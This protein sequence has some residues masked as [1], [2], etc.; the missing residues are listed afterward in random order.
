MAANSSVESCGEWFANK[1]S[2]ASANYGIGSDGRIALYVDESDRA[3]TSGSYD[4]DHQAVTIEVANCSG[5]PEWKVSEV[6]LY[7]LVRLCADICERNGIRKLE[8]TGDSS[9]NL[10]LHKF[11]RPTLCPGPYLESRMP[12]I[13]KQVNERLDSTPFRIKTTVGLIVRLSPDR[14]SQ[15]VAYAKPGVYTITD[16]V[17]AEGEEWGRLKSKAGWVLLN[18]SIVSKI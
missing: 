16:V 4:N 7:S 13:A 8:Y 2:Q 15:S 11:F 17:T 3:W 6:A 10:T 18:S 1:N 14:N 5:G 12:W 9:G